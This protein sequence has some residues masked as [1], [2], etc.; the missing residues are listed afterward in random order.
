MADEYSSA[1]LATIAS[2]A[3]RGEKLTDEEIRAMAG[4]VL[5]QHNPRAAALRSMLRKGYVTAQDQAEAIE[6][7]VQRRAFNNVAIGQ[8]SALRNI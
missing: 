7:E 1:R 3:M 6:S 5:T 4:S 8:R 2:R